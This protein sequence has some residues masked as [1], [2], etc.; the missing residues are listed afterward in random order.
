MSKKYRTATAEA[1]VPLMGTG[2][3]LG[4]QH[5][6]EKKSC[7]SK[8]Q[9]FLQPHKREK[10]KPVLWLPCLSLAEGPL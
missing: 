3:P 8:G 5:G 7:G 2:E 1:A 10:G 9:L 6:A 4:L